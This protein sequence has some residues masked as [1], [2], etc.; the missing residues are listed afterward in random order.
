MAIKYLLHLASS[1]ILYANDDKLITNFN[2]KNS[3]MQKNNRIR[4]IIQSS[5]LEFSLLLSHVK[6]LRKCKITTNSY[7]LIICYYDKL[8]VDHI[9]HIICFWF[10]ETGVNT[11]SN[12]QSKYDFL[13]DQSLFFVRSSNMDC[14]C[15]FYRIAILST[16]ANLKTKL[17][18]CF[19]FTLIDI[20]L[21]PTSNTKPR[22]GLI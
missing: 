19:W 6:I 4:G 14:T 10:V 8:L 22:N 15:V 9:F 7:M 20:D 11:R 17:S 21:Y 18:F 5:D 3:I 2:V 12:A 13:F 1:F 16:T